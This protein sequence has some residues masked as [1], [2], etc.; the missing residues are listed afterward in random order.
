MAANEPRLLSQL[1]PAVAWQIEPVGHLQLVLAP[2]LNFA[3]AHNKDS[4][5]DWD[6]GQNQKLLLNHRSA[7]SLAR[8][9]PG[10]SLG[11]RF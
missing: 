7:R 5:P 3:L 9:W 10:L 4:T 6:F 1:R 8:L 2:T 11:L